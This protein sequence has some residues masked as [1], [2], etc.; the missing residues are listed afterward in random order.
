MNR[1]LCTT[2]LLIL[3]LS[4]PG[5][6]KEPYTD[7][8]MLGKIRENIYRAAGGHCPYEAPDGIGYTKA[9]AGYRP[10]YVSHMGR[11]GSRYQMTNKTDVFGEPLRILDSLSK[12]G[13]LTASGDSLRQELG[14][15]KEAHKG[16]DG[17]LTIKGG[18]EH[19]GIASRLCARE[20]GLFSQ[21]DRQNV[22]CISTNIQRTILSM[23]NFGMALGRENPGLKISCQVGLNSIPN[24]KPCREEKP[25]TN[26]KDSIEFYQRLFISNLDAREFI[27]RISDG[28][29]GL[30]NDQT[31]RIFIAAAGAACLDEIVNPLRFFTCGELL[32]LM[33]A[34]NLRFAGSYGG[35]PEY[36]REQSRMDKNRKYLRDIIAKAD[37][38]IEGNGY[39]A[40]FVFAHD[41]NIGPLNR[42]VGIY[43]DLP[44]VNLGELW[45][46]WPS[47]ENICMATNLQIV[48]YR[49]R[50]GNVLVKIL[51]NERE[52]TLPELEPEYKN[53]YSWKKV[54]RYWLQRI[55]DLQDLPE[56]CIP[57]LDAKAMEIKSLQKDESDGF[58]FI[59]DCHFPENTGHSAAMLEYLSK[60]SSPRKIFFGGDTESNNLD[61]SEGIYP[62]VAFTEQLRG[63]APVYCVRGNHDFTTNTRSYSQSLSQRQTAKLFGFLN[64]EGFTGN[65][66]DPYSDYGY[67]DCPKAR[68]RYIFLDTTDSVKDRRI[69]YGISPSQMKWIIEEAILNCR[70]GWSIVAVTHVPL[71]R[72]F[73][74]QTPSIVNAG[75]CFA[76][77]YNH[78]AFDF[79]GTRYDFSSR[80]DLNPIMIISGHK[81]TNANSD[82]GGLLQTLANCDVAR[83][84][85]GKRATGVVS[86]QYFRY[87]SVAKDR[88]T[89]RFVNIG[90]E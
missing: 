75:D 59:T 43:E 37:A 4:V 23:A 46:Y 61:V 6:S 18:L 10:F 21:P 39:C 69:V 13:L 71:S 15:M 47:W 86:E 81:H 87:V 38:A 17:A 72:K 49:N 22:G 64:S 33:K 45:R 79:D 32:Q 68:I 76:A 65:P 82:I 89:V 44:D 88:K 19:Q 80:K 30:T 14:I 2:F 62:M 51:R 84:R 7:S 16:Y 31:Y 35:Y 74:K 73:H 36:A 57:H 41:G 52:M 5:L 63:V 90:A 77:L 85:E 50:T 54:R 67:L 3:S 56:Y 9:P 48:F 25:E 60:N 26:I 28:K 8:T 12:A 78:T 55:G 11:H 70:K 42:L 40:D 53:F 24:V 20:K 58:Y 1:Q 83:S 29:A 34:C 66:A 27:G